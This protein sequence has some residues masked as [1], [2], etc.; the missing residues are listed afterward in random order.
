MLRLFTEVWPTGLCRNAEQK[1]VSLRWAVLLLFPL[2]F[3]A[4]AH[5]DA[6]IVLSDSTGQGMSRFTGAGHASV[7]LSNVCPASPVRLRLCRPGEQGSVLSNYTTLDEDKP[8]AWNVVPLSIFLYGV[9]DPRDRPLYASQTM[10][11]LL[12]DSY[13][14]KFLSR[15]CT[16]QKC[17]TDPHAYW[18]DS[19]D[20][21]FQRATYIFAVHTTVE[22]D[23]KFIAKY[24][25]Q[26]N[27]NHYN[28]FTNNCANF[29]R[30]AINTYFPGAVRPNYLNDFGMMG[31]KAAARSF[32]RYAQRRPELHYYAEYFPQVPGN[33]PRSHKARE[34]TEAAFHQKKYFVPL[35][36]LHGDELPICIASYVVA[37]RFNPQREVARHGLPQRE[38]RAARADVESGN[39]EQD[40]N[41]YRDR[42]QASLRQTK[43]AGLEATGRQPIDIFAELATG[44]VSLDAN[45]TPWI[46]VHRAGA[47]VY[48][49]LTRRT[50][51]APGSDPGLAYAVMRARVGSFLAG[52]EADRREPISQMAADWALLGRARR[53]HSSELMAV[54]KEAVGAEPGNE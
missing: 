13:R 49:G 2:L 16:T 9:D 12:Q 50:L 53:R 14:Q 25:A 47:P 30:R 5:A 24:N 48:V 7:Y 29:A 45:G 4:R 36:L 31:P 41:A 17:R 26:A 27:V 37:G 54:H 40:W 6:G 35:L 32:S 46:C 39:A 28:G 23:E 52:H 51:L 43:E 44:T 38:S 15:I 22:Q 3:V 18:R 20:T 11:I 19:V 21:A 33:M 8:Y 1:I 10:A 34:G 42:F